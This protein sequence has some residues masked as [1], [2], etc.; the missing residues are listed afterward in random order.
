MKEGPSRN[1]PAPGRL[2]FGC[3]G[4]DRVASGYILSQLET[5]GLV[6]ALG[7][8]W[9][10]FRATQFYN[11]ILARAQKAAKLLVLPVPGGFRG[12]PVDPDEVGAWL[13]KLPSASPS[14]ERSKRARWAR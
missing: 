5:S 10:T 12:Q 14:G 3:R 2:P 8:P 9:T 7:L 13:V 4:A 11:L 1:L 6:D